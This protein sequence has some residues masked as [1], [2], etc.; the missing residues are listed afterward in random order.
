MTR[1]NIMRRLEMI[2]TTAFAC[3]AVVTFLLMRIY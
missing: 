2:V 1:E 3:N